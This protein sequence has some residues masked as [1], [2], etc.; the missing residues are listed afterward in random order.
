MTIFAGKSKKKMKL[1]I[2]TVNFNDAQGLERTIKS[3][4]LQTFRDYEFIIIDG[5][6]TDGSID[7]IKKYEDHI[8][9]WVSEPDG[10]IYQ[11]M[12]KGLSH[13]KGDYVNFM[14]GGDSYH[15]HDVL[16]KIF[17][18]NTE[19]DIIT[20][21]HV[22][23]PHPN[24]GQGGVTMLSLYTGAVD[25]QASF[26]RRELALRHPYD[27]K[28]RIVS[29]WKFFIEALIFDNCSFYYT[30]TIVVDV[31]INGI[32]NTQKELDKQ[33]RE[34]VL[35]ELFPARV[36]ADYRKFATIH[37]DLLEIAT[38]ICKSQT[39]KNVIIKLARQLLRLK[40][41]LR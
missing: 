14:N 20:G 31:D 23:S 19:A 37:S 41:A 5:G 35:Q 7:I 15:S 16:E 28:Y 40:G 4:I 6:S 18:L 9:F 36:L 22:G 24:V 29:D 10:G 26:I 11:G 8:N 12:N 1:S 17:S 30:D 38:W 25:H 39:I 32:S 27:E 21:T 33:E 3:V 34:S 13:A 2:I